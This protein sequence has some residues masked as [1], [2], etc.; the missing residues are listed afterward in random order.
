[1]T[2]ACLLDRRNPRK[3]WALFYYRV[4]LIGK[5]GRADG[6][7]N[8]LILKSSLCLDCFSY[9]TSDGLTAVLGSRVML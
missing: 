7:E 3:K 1:M 6:F 8:V 9:S 4:S 5:S 2:S